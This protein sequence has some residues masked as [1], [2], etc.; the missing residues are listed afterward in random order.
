MVKMSRKASRT[1]P[2]AGLF[3][4]AIAP[5]LLVSCLGEDEQNQNEKYGVWEFNDN[6]K[7][8]SAL[9]HMHRNG[10]IN[11]CI[12]NAGRDLASI[13]EKL[14]SAVDGWVDLLNEPPPSS[15]YPRWRHESIRVGYRCSDDSYEINVVSGSS[16]NVTMPGNYMRL[17][18]NA[19]WRLVV[20][21]IGHFLGIAETDYDDLEGQPSSLMKGTSSNF[22]K[23]DRIGVWSL[24][25]DIYRGT[26]Q[27]APGYVMEY[28]DDDEYYCRP[29]SLKRPNISVRNER[30]SSGEDIVVRFNNF[31]G[32]GWY[33]VYRPRQDNDADVVWDYLRPENSR[34][35]FKIDS[36]EL[37]RGQRLEVRLFSGSGYDAVAKSETFV[38]TR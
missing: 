5:L 3:L 34:G 13:K 30:Y 33:G 37:T 4:V 24:W 23:D 18:R 35:T 6:M 22:T 21:E 17:G 19:S 15:D 27:C 16:G 26:R 10:S 25:R 38:V 1:L 2:F 31:D 32:Y 11:F 9:W 14:E 12:K 8:Y 36:S 7:R 20:H 29:T 28:S